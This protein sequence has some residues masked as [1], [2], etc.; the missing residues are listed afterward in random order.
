[1]RDGYQPKGGLA[2]PLL[3]LVSDIGFWP[4]RFCPVQ[5]TTTTYCSVVT[6]GMFYA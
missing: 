5:E 6:R 3:S 1:M 4:L 2:I